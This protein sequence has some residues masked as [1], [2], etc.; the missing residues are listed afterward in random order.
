MLIE[1]F[2]NENW[3]ALQIDIRTAFLYG[4]LEEE[5]YMKMPE[6]MRENQDECMML[7]KS[8]YG[9]VQAARQWYVQLVRFL[10]KHD[11]LRSLIDPCLIIKRRNQELVVI[12]IYVDDCAL[13]G[14][15]DFVYE[16]IRLIASR[17][18][19]RKEEELC[20]YVGCEI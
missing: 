9:L 15:N 1:W 8:T 20:K 16:T 7:L 6:G 2:V 19:I 4:D 5:I 10:R 18:K 11:Y 3:V 13:F 17:F 14:T 12:L